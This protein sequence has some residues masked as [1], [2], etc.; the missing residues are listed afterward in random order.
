MPVAMNDT[1]ATSDRLLKRA[2]QQIH[3]LESLV[4]KPTKNP[5]MQKAAGESEASALSSSWYPRN[6]CAVSQKLANSTH[7]SVGRDR[8][9]IG[10]QRAP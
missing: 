7:F 9:M 3:P 1:T 4:A 6:T 5:P 2:K 8:E 10:G